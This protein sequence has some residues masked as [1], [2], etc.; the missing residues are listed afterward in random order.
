M[1]RLPILATLFAFAA[2][3]TEPPSPPPAS[4]VATT[5]AAAPAP[6]SDDD[7]NLQTPLE[8]G[9]PGS[10]G[11]LIVSPRNP[12]GDSELSALMRVFVDDMNEVRA[13]MLAHQPVRDLW[14]THRKMRCAWHSKPAERNAE[15]DARAQAYLAT[16]RAFDSEPGQATYNAIVDSCVACHSQSCGGPIDFI[17]G[18]RWQ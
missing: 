14:P 1:M 12:N 8:P 11:N 17:D 9:I 4:V 13:A 6:A 3:S 5:E 18:L 2:C 16:I 15:F 10:P 7:C